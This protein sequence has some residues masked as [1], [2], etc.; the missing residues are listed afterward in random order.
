[1]LNARGGHGDSFCKE[2]LSKVS[3]SAKASGVSDERTSMLLTKTEL[4]KHGFD[5]PHQPEC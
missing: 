4:Y 1:M 2:K 3:G 5:S